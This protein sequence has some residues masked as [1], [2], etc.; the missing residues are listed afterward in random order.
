M[1]ERPADAATPARLIELACEALPRMSLGDGSFCWERRL[2]TEAPSGRSL[3]YT[4]MVLLGLLRASSQGVNTGIDPE[5]VRDLLWR[6][7][8]S[9]ELHPGDFG[10]YLWAAARLGSGDGPLLADRLRQALDRDG[11]FAGREGMELGWIVTGLA[12]Q[13]A[14]DARHS[15]DLRT[16]L[17]WLLGPGRDAGSGLFRQRG[18]GPRARFPNFATQIYAVL[19]L[20]TVGRLG[21]DERALPA[22]R[23]TADRLLELQLADGGWPWIYDVRSGRVVERYEVYAV[24]QDAMA[25]MA[26]LELFEATGDERY[27]A[28]VARGLPWVSGHNELGADMVDRE[29]GLVY[30]SIRRTSPWDRGLLIANTLSSAALRR[31][32]ATGGRRLEI[33]A[34]DRPY[35]FGWVLE[36][37]SGRENVL[38]A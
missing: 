20:A 37:W 25:P 23:A 29:A 11:G 34:T 4:L 36:A 15:A 2:G 18:H 17:D 24:H 30:R 6:E 16:A 22:A 32:A 10:L 1:N 35:H 19:A 33:N 38:S 21:L 27:R 3:R 8:D 28:A 9:P 5:P 12:H 31:P 13:A 7:L 14:A 26:L